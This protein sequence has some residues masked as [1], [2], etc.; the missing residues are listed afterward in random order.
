MF[1][2]QS[3][4]RMSTILPGAPEWL[5]VFLCGEIKQLNYVEADRPPPPK[6]KF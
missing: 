1:L 3:S 4:F 6:E 5:S 2:K